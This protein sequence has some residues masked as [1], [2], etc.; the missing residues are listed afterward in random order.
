MLKNLSYKARG[1]RRLKRTEGTMTA[2]LRPRNAVDEIFKHTLYYL[3]MLPT[4]PKVPWKLARMR[5]MM[6]LACTGVMRT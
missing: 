5:S 3:P 1:K 4:H 2:T 6:F